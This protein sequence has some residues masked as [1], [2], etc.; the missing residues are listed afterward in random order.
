M[1]AGALHPGWLGTIPGW[2]TLFS[3]AIVG[4]Y[5]VRGGGGTALGVLEQAN[6]VLSRQV[7]VDKQ[8]IADLQKR[9][10]EL[11]ASRSLEAIVESVSKLF[12]SQAER[13]AERHHQLMELANSHERRAGERHSQQMLQMRELFTGVA[14]AIAEAGNGQAAA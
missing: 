9:V 2:L 8:T 11:E 7:E 12:D 1:M 4:W 14:E 10:A 3:L 13:A 5:V 6:R